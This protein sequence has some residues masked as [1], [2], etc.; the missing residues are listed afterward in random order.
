MIRLLI[1]VL[2]L[3]FTAI[4]AMSNLD[5]ATVWLAS[6]GFSIKM[7]KLIALLAVPS[8]MLGILLGLT[9][10]LRQRRRARKAES[11]LRSSHKQLI[12]LHQRLDQLKTS[13]SASGTETA[14][15]SSQK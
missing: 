8:L 7:G 2:F 5:D 6:F 3:A 1:I 11:Q 9:G 12:E 4:F 10:E 13:S 15:L 14:Q